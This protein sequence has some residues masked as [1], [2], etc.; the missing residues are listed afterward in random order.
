M[1]FK[2]YFA[3]GLIW[4]SDLP[5]PFTEVPL[6]DQET[7]VQI[8][9]YCSSHDSQLSRLIGEPEISFQEDLITMHLK[10]FVRL[11]AIRGK[12]LVYQDL[13]P[14]RPRR[15]RLLSGLGTALTLILYQRHRVILHGNAL[16]LHGK[17]FLFLGESGVGKSTLSAGL[18]ERGWNCLSDDMCVFPSAGQPSMK[19][20]TASTSF[21]ITPF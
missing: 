1:K 12:E 7:D 3:F 20:Q 21:K 6:L 14:S 15:P 19:V 17:A 5:L 8:R 18:I 11:W 13:V 4:K 10:D 9:C 16:M 2:N